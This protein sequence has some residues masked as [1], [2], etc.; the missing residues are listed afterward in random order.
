VCGGD[1]GERGGRGELDG[2]MVYGFYALQVS[3]HF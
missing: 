1:G 3:C 2:G